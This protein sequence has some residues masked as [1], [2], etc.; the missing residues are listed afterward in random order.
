MWPRR[1]AA[2]GSWDRAQVVLTSW[3]PALGLGLDLTPVQIVK[4]PSRKICVP[5]SGFRGPPTLLPNL[6]LASAT[7]TQIPEPEVGLSFL[8]H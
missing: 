8:G 7:P 6:C 1:P 5:Y 4:L 3:K 2:P